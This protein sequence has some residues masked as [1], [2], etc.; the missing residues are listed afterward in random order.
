MTPYE[1]L[2][3]ELKNVEQALAETLRHD[4]GPERTKEY[5]SECSTRLA[6]I[7]KVVPL[8][9]VS[10]LPTIS[11][12]L[13]ELRLLTS[14]IFLIERSHLGEFSWPFSEEL[15]QMAAQLLAYKRLKKDYI[16]PI[17]HVVAD[18]EG[19][20][21][22]YETRVPTASVK[23]PIIIVAFLRSLKHHVLLHAI[24]GHELGHTAL[25]TPIVGPSL[26]RSVISS[27]ARVGPMKTATTVTN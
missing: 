23:R 27:F 6:E 1:F 9:S 26:R 21:I 11:A 10:D 7:K 2:E 18:A 24:F 13:S 17:I 25:E 14:W 20:Q 3:E 12:R 15:R 4:Y 19:Y 5:Y 8:I 22:N 16:N